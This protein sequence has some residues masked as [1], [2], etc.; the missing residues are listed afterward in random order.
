MDTAS[1]IKFNVEGDDKFTQFLEKTQKSFKE[2]NEKSLR[3]FN[4]GLKEGSKNLK[5]ITKHF[6]SKSSIVGSLVKDYGKATVATNNWNASL[7]KL[8][9]T[10]TLLGGALN[11]L[12]IASIG[13]GVIKTVGTGVSEILA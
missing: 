11:A 13:T 12:N 6:Q 10:T 7:G 8:A 9:K 2:L 1:N 3:L 5:D 4:T